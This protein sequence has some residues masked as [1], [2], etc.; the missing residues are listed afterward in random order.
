MKRLSILAASIMLATGLCAC[1]SESTSTTEF[2][3]SATTDGTTTSYNYTSETVNGE[4]TVTESTEI[5]GNDI[6]IRYGADEGF[7]YIETT[8]NTEGIEV[9]ALNVKDS[10][11]VE[12]AWIEGNVYNAEFEADIVEGEGYAILGIYKD[13]SED[14]SSYIILPVYV[15]N[16]AIYDVAE[17][18]A[19]VDS[20][21]EYFNM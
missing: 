9:S 17:D 16:G 15:E 10:T 14:P 13:G 1:A 2:N 4:T 8:I 20:L 18:F 12:N 7:A 5:S 11:S 21:D 6:D 3:I 19:L